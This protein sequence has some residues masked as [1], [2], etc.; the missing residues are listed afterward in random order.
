MISN[1]NRMFSEQIIHLLSLEKLCG[2][3]SSNNRGRVIKN[4]NQII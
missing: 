2:K 1:R 3:I 4:N